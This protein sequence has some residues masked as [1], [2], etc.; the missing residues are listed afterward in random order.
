MTWNPNIPTAEQSP[1][2]SQPF[3]LLNDQTWPTIFSENHV[4]MNNNNQG[5]HT[6][7]IFQQQTVDPVVTGDWGTI[8]CKSVSSATGTRNQLFFRTKQFVPNQTNAPQQFTFNQIQLSGTSQ[9]T[10]LIGGFLLFLGAANIT[11]GSAPISTTIN[12]SP[13]TSGLIMAIAN[14]ADDTLAGT[15][16]ITT[17]ILTTSS[18]KITIQPFGS[19]STYQLKYIVI[20]RQ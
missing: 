12:L 20:G 14:F 19:L 5:K 1:A 8:Y 16:N 6:D 3:I 4:A 9:Q 2:S 10:F 18:F 11:A 7:V 17:Q 13:N 15:N